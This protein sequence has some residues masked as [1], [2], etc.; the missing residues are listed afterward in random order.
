MDVILL[1]GQSN[2]KGCGNPEKSILPDGHSYEYLENFTGSA[3]IPLYITLQRSE[4]RGTI[5]PSFCNK[6]Y[7]LTGNEVCIVHYA[8]DG[9]RI[10]NWNHDNNFFLQEALEK[11]HHCLKSLQ[12]KQ[13]LIGKKY[14]VWIQGES[15]GK[16]GTD[17]LYYEER[18]ADIGN[19]LKENGIEQTFV[20]ATG[21]W[22]GSEQ[23]LKRCE[24]IS[25]VQ[26]LLCEKSKTLTLVSKLPRTFRKQNK[27]QDEVH[28]SM[29]AL[30]E[31]GADI[32]QNMY[33]FYDKG[34]K[35]ILKDEIDLQKAK[36]YIQ[37]LKELEELP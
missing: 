10:K 5:A 31:L 14:A 12:E 6:W 13:I 17:P 37:K 34:I 30:N 28:Y 1:I 21:Y 19:V 16:Y 35:P 32:A 23:Y 18:L 25:V 20:S 29:E 36:V 11:Y 15:D 3:L 22:D 24:R 8:V 33:V 27:N 4:G 26:E 2:A 7:A 9:S